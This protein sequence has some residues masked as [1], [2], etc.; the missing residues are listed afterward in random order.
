MYIVIDPGETVG[1]ASFDASGS[2]IKSG[3]MRGYL[4][5]GVL[6]E[7]ILEAQP[8]TRVL[9][10]TYKI[11]PWVAQGGSEVPAAKNI[12]IIEWLASK[13]DVAYE[14]I[15]PKYKKIGYAWAGIKK[16]SNHALSH[17]FDAVALGEYWLRKNGIKPNDKA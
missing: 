16:P 13:N 7:S 15:D 1:Y 14:G 6:L 3:Q 8:V 9:Y 11:F 10:E 5:F 12:G 2:L 17:S 4:T